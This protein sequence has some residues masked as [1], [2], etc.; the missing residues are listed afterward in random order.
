MPRVLIVDDDPL[1]VAILEAVLG[2]EG[3]DVVTAGSLGQARPLLDDVDVVVVDG[4]LPDG[5]GLDLLG[6]PV[7]RRRT[8][9]VVLHTAT[10]PAV[11][12]AVPVVLKGAGVDALL[13][14]LRS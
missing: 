6:E 8:P 12:V 14:A 3:W 1:V 10:A 9:R 2:L 11:P 5:D 7:V 4:Q 13:A